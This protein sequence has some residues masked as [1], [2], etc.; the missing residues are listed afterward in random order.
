VTNQNKIAFYA[1]LVSFLA[2]IF[3]NIHF[4][5][6]FKE[7]SKNFEEQSKNFEEQSR[8]FREQRDSNRRELLIKIMTD[9]EMQLSVRQKAAVEYIDAGYNGVFK[10]YVLENK[11]YVK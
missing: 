6:N 4:Y 2:L 1:V 7:Q 8:N 3:T 9:K 5:Q 11:L 10:E